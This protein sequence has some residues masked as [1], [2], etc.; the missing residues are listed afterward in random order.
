M[1]AGAYIEECAERCD[2]SKRL[3][4]V[5]ATVKNPPGNLALCHCHGATPQA[6]TDKPTAGPTRAGHRTGRSAKGEPDTMGET[7]GVK[8]RLAPPD[9]RQS[10]FV[11]P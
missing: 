1:S 9:F 11:A 3:V 4:G 6:Q 2:E 7:L 8:S 10:I 5:G